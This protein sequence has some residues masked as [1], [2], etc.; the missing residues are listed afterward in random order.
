M[1]DEEL[2][3]KDPI[4][5]VTASM[6]TIC[7]VWKFNFPVNEI[8]ESDFHSLNDEQVTKVGSFTEHTKAITCVR[9]FYDGEDAMCASA[10]KDGVVYVRLCEEECARDDLSFFRCCCSAP[11][12]ALSP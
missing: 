10:D 2:T 8:T 5:L 3:E 1:A 12:L 7:N 9:G 11:A 6:D 4:Y